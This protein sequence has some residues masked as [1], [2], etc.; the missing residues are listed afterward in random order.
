MR[1]D[2]NKPTRREVKEKLALEYNSIGA[3]IC[4]DE[5]SSG[6]EGKE[7]EAENLSREN[8]FCNPTH[9]KTAKLSNSLSSIDMVHLRLSMNN[10][11]IGTNH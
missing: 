4:C 3:N 11:K 10:F 7:K 6:E 1:N 2:T 8:R 5:N 9:F